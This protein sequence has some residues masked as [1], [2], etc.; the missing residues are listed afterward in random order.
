MNFNE[1]PYYIDNDSGLTKEQRIMIKENNYY[2]SFIFHTIILNEGKTDKLP[3]AYRKKILQ[4]QLYYP[5]NKTGVN[6]NNLGEKLKALFIALDKPENRE[7]FRKSYVALAL[8]TLITGKTI[9]SEEN[10]ADYKSTPNCPS[11]LKN[12]KA[13]FQAAFA[14]YRNDDHTPVG[15]NMSK[16]IDSIVIKDEKGKYVL[17]DTTAEQGDLMMQATA[18]QVNVMKNIPSFKDNF[19]CD[20]NYFEDEHE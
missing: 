13:I 15:I 17:K 20:E 6:S 18:K 12:K 2:L 1:N 5:D 10:W 4:G 14:C 3:P 8:Q 19:R 11:D 9:E 7:L 16:L